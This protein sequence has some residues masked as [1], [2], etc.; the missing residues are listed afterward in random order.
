MRIAEL[1]RRAGVKVSTI[2]YYERCSVL[3]EPDRTGTGY[4]DYDE[5]SLRYVRFLRRGQ[6]LG[7]T[8]AELAEFAGYS[9][10]ARRGTVSRADVAAVAEAKLR[11]LDSRIDDLRRTRAAVQ[12][13]LAVECIDP[14]APCPV[15]SALADAPSSARA[16]RSA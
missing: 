12:S 6:E 2:R 13:L 7:F 11:D 15:V 10:Q 8:L 16:N 4:R 3:P 1:S 14:D 9:A 5:E